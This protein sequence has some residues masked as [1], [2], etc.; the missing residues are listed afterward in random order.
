MWNVK[1]SFTH[2]SPFPW[3]FD[4][5]LCVSDWFIQDAIRNLWGFTKTPPPWAKWREIWNAKKVLCE[6]FLICSTRFHFFIIRGRFTVFR[7][8]CITSFLVTFLLFSRLRLH[9]YHETLRNDSKIWKREK[10]NDCEIWKICRV[11]LVHFTEH[12]FQISYFMPFHSMWWF[13]DET[14]EV[15]Y[16][17]LCI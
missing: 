6:M 17:V 3:N 10:W 14:P 4:S 1:H 5:K 9:T 15:S 7:D 11:C 12:L 13:L 2:F 8:K 16:R